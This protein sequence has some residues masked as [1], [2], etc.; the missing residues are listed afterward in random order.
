[1]KV[2]DIYLD[3]STN[4]I[5]TIYEISSRIYHKGNS[6]YTDS[7]DKDDF[8]EYYID[9]KLLKNFVIGW[10]TI[11]YHTEKNNKK[12]IIFITTI[13]DKIYFIK[14]MLMSDE[15]S[16]VTINKQL[17]YNHIREEIEKDINMR[18]NKV[19]QSMESHLEYLKE[20][21]SEYS[22]PFILNWIMETY[23]ECAIK[24]SKLFDNDSSSISNLLINLFKVWK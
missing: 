19:K 16:Y 23:K 8:N 4:E 18:F 10:L 13:N 7:D 12:K 14:Q 1:M 9:I 20:L 3:K 11:Y 21:S 24:A 6:W 22:N 2:W 15:E 5:R 17:V